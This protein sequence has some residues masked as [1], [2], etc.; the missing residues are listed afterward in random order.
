MRRLA[1]P[2]PHDPPISV[3]TA[4]SHLGIGDDGLLQPTRLHR[5]ETLAPLILIEPIFINVES[6][7]VL[8]LQRIDYRWKIPESRL[9][10]Q[11]RNSR[12]SGFVGRI[13]SNELYIL[14]TGRH[15]VS[16]LQNENGLHTRI[17]AQNAKGSS[18]GQMTDS[19]SEV[20]SPIY[21]DINA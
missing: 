19:Q 20:T 2:P 7:Y 16:V 6:A 11:A 12:L 21:N 17:V 4:V 3:N 15:H 1:H 5:H 14:L 10:Y 9:S 8:I 18:V 13:H